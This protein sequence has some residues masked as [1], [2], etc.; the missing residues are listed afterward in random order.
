MSTYFTYNNNPLKINIDDTTVK[1]YMNNSDLDPI[2]T[3]NNI[4]K[5]FIDNTILIHR[6]KNDYIFIGDKIFFFQA[7]DEINRFSSRFDKKN[8]SHPYAIDKSDNCYL[9]NKNVI[10]NQD[11][12]LRQL[13]SYTIY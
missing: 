3:F 11:N 8:I 10:L 9:L 6:N 13:D 4:K 5:T 2:L 1:V 7:L 12:N